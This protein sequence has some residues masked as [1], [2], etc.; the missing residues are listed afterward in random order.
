MKTAL[1]FGAI[2]CLTS[3]IIG[4]LLNDGRILFF[5]LIGGFILL[6]VHH[7]TRNK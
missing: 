2:I 3:F 1:D 4:L 5:G 6:T 7:I